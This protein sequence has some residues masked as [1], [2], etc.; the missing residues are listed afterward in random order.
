MK[1]YRIAIVGI[2]KI[3]EDQHLPVI[4][5]NPRFQLAALVSQRGV[6]RPGVP[7]FKTVEEMLAAL[8]DVE[9]V[10]ICTPPNVRHGITR[11]VLDAGRHALLEKPTTATISELT[12]LI[13]HAAATRRVIYTTW[14]S[15][16]NAGVETAKKLLQGKKIARLHINWKEDVRRWHPGQ[17]WIWQA[18]GFGVFDPGINALSIVTRILPAPIFVEKA[19]LRFPANRDT[20]IAADLRFKTAVGGSQDLRAEFDWRQTGP[21]TWNITIATTEGQ[22]LALTEGGSKLAVDGKPVVTEALA[23]YEAIYERF[24]DL[25]DR[26]ESEIDAAPLQLVADAFLV[27]RRVVTDSFDW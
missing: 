25:L 23:E 4:A 5:K 12:D 11:T 2:G 3:T 1:T 27:G 16:Y 9:A 26:Q 19:E 14:H 10:A 20:P 17:E 21:Q 13:D 15:Q 22:T 18:G 7:S 24:A 8:P 6:V